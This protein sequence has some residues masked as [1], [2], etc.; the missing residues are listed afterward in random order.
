MM[1]LMAV[2]TFWLP[3]P[4]ALTA[5]AATQ[6]SCY[7]VTIFCVLKSL[8][9]ESAVEDQRTDVGIGLIDQRCNHCLSEGDRYE[10]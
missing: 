9:Q 7:E 8:K 5:A 10:W 1:L 4:M 6:P 2:K 3:V